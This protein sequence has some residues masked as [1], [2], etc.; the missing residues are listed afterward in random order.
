MASSTACAV[1][2]AGSLARTFLLAI[3]EARSSKLEGAWA[4]CC[5]PTIRPGAAASRSLCRHPLLILQA[6][7]AKF[8][9]RSQHMQRL[10]FPNTLNQTLSNPW[11]PIE[12]YEF[13]GAKRVFY[14]S[15][16]SSR[17]SLRTY[18]SAVDGKPCR[19]AVHRDR[20]TIP[21][22]RFDLQWRFFAVG[23]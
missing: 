6:V 11:A 23:E 20:T 12:L 8:V 3:V 13:A 1:R 17:I 4:S 19:T 21:P 16:G 7:S 15:L 10:S 14:R 9:C 18:T 2:S 22:G 5:V